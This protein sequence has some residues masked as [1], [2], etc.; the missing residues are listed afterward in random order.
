MTNV[1]LRNAVD[2]IINLVINFI[3]PHKRH[4]DLRTVAAKLRA[5]IG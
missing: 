4:R 1:E 2:I 5:I 3:F